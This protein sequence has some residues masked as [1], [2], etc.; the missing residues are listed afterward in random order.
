MV[1]TNFFYVNWKQIS[2]L[3]CVFFFVS[4]VGAQNP[5]SPY[6]AT[7]IGDRWSLD[8]SFFS[9]LGNNTVSFFDSTVLN[10]YQP[11]SYNTMAVGQPLFSIGISSKYVTSSNQTS[12]YSNFNAVIDHFGLGM[13][14]KKHF[15]LAF[16][17]KPFSTRGYELTQRVKVGDDSLKYIYQGKGGTNQAFV[18]FSSNIIKLRTL[19]W[20]VGTNMSYL[21]GSVYNERKSLIISSSALSGGVD[22]HNLRFQSFYYELGTYLKKEIGEHHSVTLSG[23]F[24]PNQKIRAKLDEFVAYSTNVNNPSL[25]DT[26]TARDQVKGNVQLGNVYE[27]GLNY[28]FSF[29]DRQGKSDDFRN[30]QLN[31]LLSYR[32]AESSNYKTN[33]NSIEQTLDYINAYSINFGIQYAPEY[34]YHDNSILT[35]V[36]EKTRYRVGMYHRGL[37]TKINGK[38]VIDQ[39]L[40]FG[41]GIPILAQQSLSQINLGFTY[42]KRGEISSSS[43]QEKY[44]GINIGVTLAPSNFDRWF[45]KRKLD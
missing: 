6:S 30:S 39:G 17:L 1:F 41:F 40:T 10:T 35:N 2:A 9:G 27:F 45:R 44:F 34:R 38:Q 11:A 12:S 8:H 18:G 16:G 25:Y 3:I 5:T 7:G 28:A 4:Q 21:F 32:L 29:R 43:I 19:T 36:L 26:L 33:F 24:Q 23:V 20:A 42:G 37:P 31:I 15:G 22:Q 14:F 13:H